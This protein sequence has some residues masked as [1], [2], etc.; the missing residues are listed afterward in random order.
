MPFNE[1]A[2]TVAANALRTTITHG[3]L[4]DSYAGANGLDNI[5]ASRQPVEWTTPTG[6][7]DFGLASASTFTGG[8]PFGSIYSI[9]LW[10]AET[11]GTMYGEFPLE[12]DLTFNSVGEY[13]VTAIDVFGNVTEEQ[14]GS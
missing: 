12:N 8:E 13:Q 14:G 7:G 9:T 1:N 3:Q 10:D 6:I 4:H 11:D 5:A 2:M